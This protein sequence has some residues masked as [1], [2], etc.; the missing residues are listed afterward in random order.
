MWSWDDMAAE[1]TA[2]F[3]NNIAEDSDAIDLSTTFHQIEESTGSFTTFQTSE[4][5]HNEACN[6][7]NSEFYQRA[8]KII[9]HL[10]SCRA[11]NTFTLTG[12]GVSKASYRL[13]CSSCTRTLSPAIYGAIFEAN[14]GLL[15]EADKTFFSS[16]SRSAPSPY[17]P[18][19]PPRA[20]R[21]TG[22]RISKGKEPLELDTEPSIPSEPVSTQQD[23]VARS[24]GMKQRLET[25]SAYVFETVFAWKL[26]PGVGLVA[27]SQN[28]LF[29]HLHSL[30]AIVDETQLTTALATLKQVLKVQ[31]Q[32][33]R[34]LS[35]LFEQERFLR[36]KT[37][38][39]LKSKVQGSVPLSAPLSPSVTGMQRSTPGATPI[40]GGT[41]TVPLGSEKSGGSPPLEVHQG[42]S[43]AMIRGETSSV[44]QK[45]DEPTTQK[46]TGTP[47]AGKSNTPVAQPQGMTQNAQRVLKSG[48]EV[49]QPQASSPP[50]SSPGVEEPVS[51]VQTPLSS[52]PPVRPNAWQSGKLVFQTNVPSEHWA[53]LRGGQW[54]VIE[55]PKG[56]RPV[57]QGAIPLPKGSSPASPPKKLANFEREALKWSTDNI[58]RFWNHSD[59]KAH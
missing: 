26:L 2:A 4:T 1:T 56:Q 43:S 28:A 57:G 48:T 16:F 12:D 44:P 29:L 25:F 40:P 18:K 45:A 5:D 6:E 13:R 52:E 30:E 24:V 59:K 32:S 55:L 7:W 51:G 20:T 41:K 53:V 37:E 22:P 49:N 50:G 47:L 14:F 58:D 10:L 19:G 35:K 17:A 34:A 21:T 27:E 11:C 33:L 3:C 36:V 23:L 54:V 38:S 9:R 15:L 31:D 8:F 39:S 42:N 46:T